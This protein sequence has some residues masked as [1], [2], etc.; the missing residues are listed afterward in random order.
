MVAVQSKTCLEVADNVAD[1]DG[2]GRQVAGGKITFSTAR[3]KSR[4]EVSGDVVNDG[5][6]TDTRTMNVPMQSY[7]GPP[8]V[9]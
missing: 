2:L 6:A 3:A 1:H 5:A 9:L 8:Q 7:M 4:T